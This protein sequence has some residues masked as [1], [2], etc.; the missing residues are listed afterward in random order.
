MKK[1]GLIFGALIFVS[2]LM[3][4]GTLHAEITQTA[5][6]ATAA[7]DYTSGAHSV[8]SVDPA[9]GP[10]SAQ[11]KLLPTGS[12]VTIAAYGN[13]FYRIGRY[14][15]DHIIKF[16]VNAPDTPI[17][18]FSTLEGPDDT[19]ANPHGMVFVSDEKAYLFMFGKAKAWIVNPSATDEA[20]FKTG[21]LN[22][23]SYGDQDGIPEMESAVIVKGKMYVIMKRLDRDNSWEPNTPYVAVIDVATDAEIDTG[24]ANDDGVKGIPLP[25][26][27]PNGIHYLA[28]NNTI[29][30]E[31][32]GRYPS[33]WSGTPAEYSGGV[34]TLNP[35]TY[36]TQLLL[37]DDTNGDGTPLYGGNISGLALVSPTKAYLTIYADAGDNS[38]RSFNPSTGVVGGVVAGLENK[39]ISGMTSGAYVDKDGMLW[40]CNQTDAR[41]D[42]INTA[43]DTLDE[44][45][46]TGLNPLKVV[47]CE[48]FSPGY[49]VDLLWL[50]A[51]IKTEEKGEI[52]GLWKEGGSDT[53]EAGDRVVYGHI[54]ADPKD[55]TWGSPSN[56]DVFV[57]IWFDHSGR[58]DVNFF[59]VSVP[60]VTVYS[61]IIYSSSTDSLLKSTLTTESRYIRHGY[62]GGK[63]YSE[64]R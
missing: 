52:E 20:N 46:S 8:I 45:I 18:Q 4:M 19:S 62:G 9:G 7:A 26:K 42:I 25:V 39:S 21:E 32:V 34:V 37:D 61:N 33:S 28:E 15:M 44:S 11:N 17:W 53:T 6:V 56:P 63:S 10:R 35:D 14:Q 57:K 16:D 59:H 41:M 12:D 31:G 24:I 55:V 58:I 40:V 54:Y 51:V 49:I 23:S 48:V 43:D 3:G 36:A 13:Y 2:L 5:V 27:N 30:V 1:R 29:Y 38:L 50:R 22:L 47:F 60:E 64:S